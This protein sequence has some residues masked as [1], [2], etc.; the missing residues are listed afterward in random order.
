MVTTAL[1]QL[2]KR[3]HYTN[4]VI[5]EA[6]AINQRQN[7]NMEMVCFCLIVVVACTAV[8]MQ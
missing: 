3:P 2:V 5:V 6:T 7:R 8:A 4:R 1:K